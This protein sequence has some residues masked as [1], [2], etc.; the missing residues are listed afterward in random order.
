MAVEIVARAGVAEAVV[1][2]FDP[3]IER[4][5][6]GAPARS[7]AG[8]KPKSGVVALV[9]LRIRGIAR[10]I[11]QAGREREPRRA[12]R[13]TS[14]AHWSGHHRATPSRHTGTWTADADLGRE[15][16]VIKRCSER[17]IARTEPHAGQ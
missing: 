4:V 5:G 9:D 14:K 1:F 7:W 11:A 17:V 13:A 6:A 8:G 12:V 15:R 16:V 2:A 10:H 3:N